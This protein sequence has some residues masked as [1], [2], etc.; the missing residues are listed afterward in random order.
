M[1]NSS[2]ICVDASLVV[3]LYASVPDER[4]RELWGRWQQDRQQLVAPTLLRFEVTNALYRYQKAGLVSADAT[5]RA[6][7]TAL[8]LPIQF[9]GDVD[10]HESALAM[11]GRFALPA[12]YDAHYLALA[13]RLGATFFTTDQRL[14]NVVQSALSWVHVVGTNH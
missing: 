5:K 2:T 12:A 3:G 13:E 10:L 14:A 6:L 8:A 7:N 1:R 4:V 9:Y 11:A